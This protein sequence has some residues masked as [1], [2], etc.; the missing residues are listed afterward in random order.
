MTSLIDISPSE[1]LLQLLTTNKGLTF[2]TESNQTPKKLPGIPDRT[3]AFIVQSAGGT[4]EKFLSEEGKAHVR[5]TIGK[6]CLESD[7]NTRLLIQ[8]LGLLNHD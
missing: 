8:V 1:M 5:L 7:T 4:I 3:L 2:M 6:H